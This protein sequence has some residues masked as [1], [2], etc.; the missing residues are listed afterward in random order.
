MPAT[1]QASRA[2]I[3]GRATVDNVAASTTAPDGPPVPVALNAPVTV[4]LLAAGPAGGP[5]ASATSTTR[6]GPATSTT[7]R[8]TTTTSGGAS[9]TTTSRVS[10][11]TSTAPATVELRTRTRGGT[12][13]LVDASDTALYVSLTDPSGTSNCDDACA[14]SWVPLSGSVTGQAPGVDPGRIGTVAGPG[15]S[16]HVT[17]YGRP[18]YRHRGEPAGGATGQGIDNRW[19]LIEP[20]GDPVTT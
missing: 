5:T 2:T 20:G 9:S 4:I 16:L 13:V 10:T 19:Y 12:V 17:Y 11:T 15:G 7:V 6:S 18:L 1:R 8:S 14:L 3:A